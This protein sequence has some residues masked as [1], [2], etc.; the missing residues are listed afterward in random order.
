M[1]FSRFVMASRDARS[2]FQTSKAR[3][4]QLRL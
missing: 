2:G 4:T 3:L 1:D